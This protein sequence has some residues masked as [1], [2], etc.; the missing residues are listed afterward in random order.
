MIDALRDHLRLTASFN[1]SP[2][3]LCITGGKTSALATIGAQIDTR[4][5]PRIAFDAL[6]VPTDDE[7][8][9][10]WEAPRAWQKMMTYHWVY[11]ARQI[12][13][14]RP[15]VVLEGQFDPQYAIAACASYR[16]RNR[17]VLVD[18]GDPEMAPWAENARS[19]GGTIV[20]GK[21]APDAVAAAICTV[22]MEL[23]A[24]Q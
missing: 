13:R 6:G 2:A 19:L 18:V 4:L 11:T 16:T 12:Y 14:M 23:L 9:R 20:D 5:M 8:T 21:A 1:G 7:M 10:C 17:V 22:A 24:T 3:L 15:L